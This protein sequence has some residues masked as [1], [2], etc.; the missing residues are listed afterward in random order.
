MVRSEYLIID[1]RN[2]FDYQGTIK[3]WEDTPE[4]RKYSYRVYHDVDNGLENFS[5]KYK[6][7][8]L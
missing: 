7:L 4:G 5:I 2:N 8:Y 1:E 6:Y 3:N